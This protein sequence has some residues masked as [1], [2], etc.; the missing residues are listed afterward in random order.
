LVA[1]LEGL[2][3]EATRLA[4]SAAVLG[5]NITLRLAAELTGLSAES[6]AHCARV[7]REARILSGED[8]ALEFA[9]PLIA[10]AVY[11]SVPAAAR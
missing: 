5:T 4:W 8:D 2:G 3:T 1:T 11:R 10:T 7:L 9:H 6:A